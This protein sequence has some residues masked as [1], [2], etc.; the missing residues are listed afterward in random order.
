MKKLLSFTLMAVGLLMMPHQAHAVWYRGAPKE[1]F[2]SSPTTGGIQLTPNISTNATSNAA[3]NPG[4]IYQVIL[5]S[6]AA[7]EYI[8]MYDSTNCT[9][10]AT[11]TAIGNLPAQ[12]YG[13]LGPHLIYSSTT[14]NT[15]VTFD[16]PIRFDQ[17]LCFFDSATSGSASITYELG[18][19]VSG[20]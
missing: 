2:V 15:V 19:G 16:P 14:A 11:T 6:G 4:A 13:N 3:Y 17:G 9:G 1:V 5:S 8:V 10:L 12:T 7:S 20:Q 18:R